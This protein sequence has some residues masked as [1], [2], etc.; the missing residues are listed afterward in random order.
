MIEKLYLRIS[1]KD[2]SDFGQYYNTLSS[3]KKTRHK[4]HHQILEPSENGKK[5][6]KTTT[7]DRVFACASVISI[8]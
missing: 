7:C 5:E 3:I 4:R 6:D 1:H 8:D 2:F